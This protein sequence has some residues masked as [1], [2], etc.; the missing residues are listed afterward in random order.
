MGAPRYNKVAVILHWFIG[1]FI[2]L[3][4]A[5]GFWMGDLPKD[6]PKT[7]TLDLFNWGIYTITLH[8]P[9][10]PRTFYFNLHK[11]IGVTLLALII[12]RIFWRLT[13]KAPDFP[14]TMRAWEKTLAEYVHKLLYL[15]MVAMPLSGVLTAVNSK[16][17]ILWFGIPLLGGMDN[18]AMRDVYKEAHEFIGT[19][20]LILVLL[21]IA[22]AI[23]HKVV[24]KDDVMAR[25][26]LR[27]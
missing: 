9:A 22:A 10:S 6:L 18:P 26:S 8:E 12:F 5:L 14:S 2:L 23:K 3:M 15:L 4:F 7:E 27:Q 25:M 16:Y 20:L 1:L 11:S 19:V 17:G 21:H 13:N 24:D